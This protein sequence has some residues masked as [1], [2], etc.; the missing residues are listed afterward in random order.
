MYP[1]TPVP[2]HNGE[3]GWQTWCSVPVIAALERQRQEDH[4]RLEVSLVY[5]V[6]QH[7]KTKQNKK[8]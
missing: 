1:G 5:T 6:R 3:A 7:L 4:C 8:K 2:T